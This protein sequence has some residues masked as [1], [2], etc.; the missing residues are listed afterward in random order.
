MPIN[1][2]LLK[3]RVESLAVKS[4]NGYVTSSQ[5]NSD[6][7][8]ANNTLY[9]YYV[10]IFEETQ[11]ILD[12]LLPF[13]KETNLPLT[14]GVFSAT[15]PF[16]TDYRHDLEVGVNKVVNNPANECSDGKCKKRS[17]RACN[18]ATTT[19]EPHTALPPIITLYPADYMNTDEERYTLSSAIRKPSMAKNIFRYTYKN[20]IIHVY[21]KEVSSIYYKYLRNP[22]QPF[23]GSTLVSNANGDYEAYDSATSVQIE[24][25]EQEFSNIVDL[26]CFYL[27]IE[28]RETPLIQFA[29]MKLTQ[30][31]IQ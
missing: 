9:E 19:L 5:Y 21:P 11:R 28:I 30:P 16:P 25:P 29:K 23:W 15:T 31:L 20:G 26:M 7:I 17:C 2:N 1:V 22:L 18:P 14:R 13:V 27:G 24:F 10:N 8:D 3:E 6:L 12:A 4:Q